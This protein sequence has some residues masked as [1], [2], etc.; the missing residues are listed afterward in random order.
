MFNFNRYL[1]SN[2]RPY[3]WL[4]NN[5]NISKFTINNKNNNKLLF[6]PTFSNINNLNNNNNNN[7]KYNEIK[8]YSTTPPNSSTPPPIPPTFGKISFFFTQTFDKG[9]GSVSNK[10]LNLVGLTIVSSALFSLVMYFFDNAV[11]DDEYMYRILNYFPSTPPFLLMDKKGYIKKLVQEY[12]E[13]TISPTGLK[14]IALIA[15][16]L[17]GDKYL[18]KY[19]MFDIVCEK[20]I[21]KKETTLNNS[22]Q[23]FFILFRLSFNSKKAVPN[24]IVQKTEKTHFY[25]YFTENEKRLSEL[26]GMVESFKINSK[27]V[28]LSLIVAP[29]FAFAIFSRRVSPTTLFN[30][31]KRSAVTSGMVMSGPLL[32]DYMN[33]NLF[34]NC[35]NFTCHAL[36]SQL[37]FVGYGLFLLQC[38]HFSF[39]SWVLP[40]FT[41]L[42]I[43]KSFEAYRYIPKV[44]EFLRKK[45]PRDT[46]FSV[47]QK[48]I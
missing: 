44:T 14:I 25:R 13:G 24:E 32:R 45:K 47:E 8:F 2:T 42:F 12:K 43:T 21:S 7:N 40:V 19:D 36:K 18:L 22:D 30:S 15:S 26:E 27:D 37:P 34:D 9:N 46:D 20:V 38:S 5:S 28:L 23:D 48:S 1:A 41:T 6:T 35:E 17:D 11:Q 29:M 39:I 31:M 16:T 4:S 33:E 3:K 10:F